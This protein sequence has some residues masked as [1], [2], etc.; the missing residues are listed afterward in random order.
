MRAAPTPSVLRLVQ[1]LVHGRWRATGEG[2]YQEIARITGA[3][4]GLELL[5]IG[6]G[7]GVTAQWLAART[8]ASVAGIDADAECI[9]RAE[10]RRRASFA[11]LPLS[12]ESAPLTDLPHDTSVFD[13]TIGEASM[14]AAADPA[15]ALREMVRVTKPM[16]IVVVLVPSWSAELPAETRELIVERLGLRPRMLVEWK[17]MLREAGV[18]EI[19]VQDWSEPPSR[20]AGPGAEVRLSWSQKA[21]IMGRAWMFWGAGG[22]W[23][24]GLPAGRNAVARET[25]VLRDLA[26]ERSLGFQLM[27]GVK[28]PHPREE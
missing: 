1:S 22:G 12:F 24:A 10:Q 18:V 8:G 20:A 25:G 16:G 28:W 23:R 21:H 17:R 6:C 2:L 19:E 26:R 5:V 11:G 4:P 7:D 3:A 9:A 13:A 14:A 27:Y 15:A